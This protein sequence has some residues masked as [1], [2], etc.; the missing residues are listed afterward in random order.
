MLC[1]NFGLFAGG[2]AAR[3]RHRHAVSAERPPGVRRNDTFCI[4]NEDLCTETEGN[5]VLQ[6]R[7]C[8]YKM[9]DFAGSAASFTSK[10]P[11]GRPTSIQT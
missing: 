4:K 1:R 11:T 7:N 3:P 9:M 5:F 8:V 2:V 6:T 10:A